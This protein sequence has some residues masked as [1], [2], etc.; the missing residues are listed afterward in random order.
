MPRERGGGRRGSRSRGS[1]SLEGATLLVILGVMPVVV[2]E[3]SCFVE[4]GEV[5]VAV[6][7]ALMLSAFLGGAMVA[8][9][10]R[11]ASAQSFYQGIA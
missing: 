2:E 7:A 8:F 3:A 5:V 1:G 10:Y 11:E 6:V 9:P 4:V